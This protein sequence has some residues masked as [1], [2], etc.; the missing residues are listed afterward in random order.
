M[1]RKSEHR[2]P[3]WV[4]RACGE[5]GRFPDDSRCPMCG[6]EA[7]PE[8]ASLAVDDPEILLVQFGLLWC[9][10]IGSDRPVRTNDRIDEWLQAEGLLGDIDL[11]DVLYR[12][13]ADWGVRISEDEFDR[14]FGLPCSDTEWKNNRSSRFT[15]GRLVAL[16]QSK[17]PGH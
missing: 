15:F 17:I 7:L 2:Y 3:W 12:I 1:I 4:C 5:G 6:K 9:N 8:S 10:I 13:E 14:F 11:A 16:I